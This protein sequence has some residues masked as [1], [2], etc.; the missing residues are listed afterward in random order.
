MTIYFSAKDAPKAQRALALGFFDGVHRGHLTLLRAMCEE[1]ENRHLIPSVF[2]FQDPPGKMF[3]PAF[4]GLIQEREDR[5]QSLLDAGAKDIIAV[6]LIPEIY[7][8]KPE[9]FL[10]RY[11][12]EDLGVKAAFAGEDFRFGDHASGTKEMLSDFCKKHG[13]SLSLLP[14]ACF[15]GRKLSS[16]RIREALQEGR[17]H[18][19]T[20]MMGRPFQQRG[21]I[22]RGKQLGRRLGFPTANLRPSPEL[23]IPRPGV[24]LSEVVWDGRV[25]PAVT[26]IGYRPS[27]EESTEV[28]SESYIF[29]SLIPQYGD[30]ITVRYLDF[31][32]PE[33]RFH[34]AS[35]LKEQVLS[36]KA[37]AKARH[38]R[39]SGH[40]VLE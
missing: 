5:F 21:I 33:K 38:E 11:F 24:Y 17:C 32:R 36:D 14:D 7:Q 37:M 23:L 4:K 1:A 34:S 16:T 25:L 18:E 26:N 35:E 20:L 6:P 13:I 2:T 40:P 10:K 22:L 3:N 30:S 12:L 9:T 31:M 28:R 27:V 15:E 19:A 29:S 8:M 39:L